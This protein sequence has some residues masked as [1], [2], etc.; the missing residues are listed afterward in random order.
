MALA[1]ITQR[2]YVLCGFI[3]VTAVLVLL[4]NLIADIGHAVV[5]PRIRCNER[6]RLRPSSAVAAPTTPGAV[7]VGWRCAASFGIDGVIGLVVIT[8]LP[9]SI[10]A[11]PHRSESRPG[12][13]PQA[14]RPR[15]ST[16]VTQVATC[17]A[18]SSTPGQVSLTVGLV[19]ALCPPPSGWCSAHWLAPIAAGRTR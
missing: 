6:R 9:A 15:P 1:S 14:A 18:G 12:L 2:D 17:S 11:M 4:S 16:G 5:D 3:P 8:R 19:A 7:A 10:L 13:F